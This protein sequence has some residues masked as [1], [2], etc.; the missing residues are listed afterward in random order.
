MFQE[1]VAKARRE[2]ESIIY[3]N[4][5][6]IIQVSFACVCAHIFALPSLVCSSQPL[7][8]TFNFIN[9]CIVLNASDPDTGFI[10][11]SAQMKLFNCITP[12]QSKRH[13]FCLWAQMLKLCLDLILCF[14]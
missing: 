9:R 3:H 5:P 1:T 6:F 8:C 12:F 14:C 11:P 10:D 7:V 2:E 4:A 13:E